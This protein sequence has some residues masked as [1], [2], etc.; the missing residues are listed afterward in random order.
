MIERCDFK[1]EQCA[2]GDEECHVQGVFKD[3]YTP[4]FTPNM[5]DFVF[6][7]AVSVILAFGGFSMVKLAQIDHQIAMERV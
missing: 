3:D 6:V 5:V 4:L 1:A 2:C 7:I